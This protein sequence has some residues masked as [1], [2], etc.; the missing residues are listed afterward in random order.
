V[1]AVFTF[2]LAWAA[3]GALQLAEANTRR[4][5]NLKQL[6]TPVVFLKKKNHHHYYLLLNNV[7]T[8]ILKNPSASE[9]L[10]HCSHVPFSPPNPILSLLNPHSCMVVF[11]NA[12]LT[13]AVFHVNF[14]TY[15]L[16]RLVHIVDY[17]VL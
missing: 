13:A 8:S 15:L 5:Y 3:P 2:V 4:N 9:S 16:L 7:L 10:C 11:P 12:R 6:P 17:T 1:G 14:I